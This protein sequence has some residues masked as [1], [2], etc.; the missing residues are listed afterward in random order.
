MRF[1]IQLVTDTGAA[2]PETREITVVERSGDGFAIADLGLTLIEAKKLLAAAQSAIT[3]AQVG[4]LARR[5]R[6]CPCCGRPRRLKDNNCTITVRTP[7]GKLALPSPRYERCGC[8]TASG[9]AAPVVAAL[10]ERVTPDLSPSKP[11]GPRSS[12]TA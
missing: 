1:I 12:P 9:V 8:E 3:D 6:P 11:A 4:D 5:E 10:P 7:F 2:R